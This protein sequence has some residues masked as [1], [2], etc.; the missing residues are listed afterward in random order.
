M[1]VDRSRDG[2]G[3]VT[4]RPLPVGAYQKLR[5]DGPVIEGEVPEVQIVRCEPLDDGRYSV[6]ARRS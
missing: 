5:V 3:F 6:G 4:D 1:V 2:V